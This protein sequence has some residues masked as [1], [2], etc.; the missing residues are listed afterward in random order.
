MVNI[1]GFEQPGSKQELAEF[2]QDSG[3]KR[4]KRGEIS[5]SLV[6]PYEYY[7]LIVGRIIFI[8]LSIKNILRL[9]SNF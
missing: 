7:K 9:S 5:L 6:E 1:T 2:R 8:F 4:N 3:F